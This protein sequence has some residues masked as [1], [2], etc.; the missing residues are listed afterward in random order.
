MEFKTAPH[1][2]AYDKTRDCLHS[3]FGEV[4]VKRA[5][6]SF[7]LQEGST[8]VYVRPLPVG[9]SKSVIEIF[10]YVAVD[11]TITEAL[12]RFL[13]VNNPRLILGAFGLS[14]EADGRGT[15]V[16]SH[17]ILGNSV[18]SDQLYGSVSAVARVADEID[19]KIVEMFGGS[20]ALDKLMTRER[21]TVE[22]WE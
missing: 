12:L 11:V 22:H 15:I 1:R 9:E 19:E 8:F 2:Q 17:S 21:A 4:N 14:V 6:D 16:L 7:V 18:D 10:A 5:G 13:L 3:I 20:T